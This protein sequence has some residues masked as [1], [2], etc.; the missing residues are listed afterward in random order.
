MQGHSN[1]LNGIFRTDKFLT[2]ERLLT[3]VYTYISDIEAFYVEPR[4]LLPHGEFY[5]GTPI[6]LDVR[7]E[8]IKQ[9][10]PIVTHGNESVRRIRRKI[11]NELDVLADHVQIVINDRV[12]PFSSDRFL[13]ENCGFKSQQVCS[14]CIIAFED[15]VIFRSTMCKEEIKPQ[16]FLKLTFRPHRI[17][18]HHQQCKQGSTKRKALFQKLYQFCTV[19][20]TLLMMT[21]KSILWKRLVRRIIVASFFLLKLYSSLT[22]YQFL[23]RKILVQT[24]KKQQSLISLL[25]NIR[26]SFLK[27][28][29]YLFSGCHSK[30]DIIS[31]VIDA[32]RR[33]HVIKQQ[34]SNWNGKTLWSNSLIAQFWMTMQLSFVVIRDKSCEY[35]TCGYRLIVRVSLFTLWNSLPHVGS[36][37]CRCDCVSQID[38]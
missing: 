9:P 16:L 19:F 20:F 37:P 29:D 13:L 15:F 14:W 31:D 11:A 36:G 21:A 4:S 26:N 8:S 2:I 23:N 7:P 22:V 25:Y 27:Y 1:G 24:Q 35:L 38:L 10:F 34:R 33:W 32:N 17:N 3:I 6:T 12:I 28:N 30:D 5:R 18:C